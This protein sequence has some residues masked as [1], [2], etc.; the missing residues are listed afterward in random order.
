MQNSLLWPGTPLLATHRSADRE[1]VFVESRV[2][3]GWLPVQ[4]VAWV[5]PEQARWIASL[6]LA[7][8]L[9]DGFSILDRRGDFLA[10]GR[11]GMVVP[12]APEQPPARDGQ[13]GWLAVLVPV[14][15]ALGHAHWTRAALEPGRAAPMPL[16]AT[17]RTLAGLARELMGQPY[18]WGGLYRNRDCSSTL[19]DLFAGLGVHLP[20]NSRSQAGAG[21]WIDLEG[22]PPQAREALI[23]ARGKPWLTLAYRPGHIMLYLGGQHGAP[24]F[25]HT[26]WG[27]TTEQGGREGRHVVGRTVITSLRLGAPLDDLAGPEALLL[28]A[29]TGLSVLEPWVL[30]DR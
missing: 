18:G 20:R 15:G 23:A 13:D 9:E 26:M 28:H 10:H 30:L 19:Q 11:I 5:S 12:L 7:A 2:A 25:L 6:P 22:V 29:L 21:R 8:P 16:P 24:A 27:V 4:D 1:W 17:Q 14:R 3:F